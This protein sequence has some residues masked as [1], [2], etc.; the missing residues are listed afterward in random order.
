METNALRRRRVLSRSAA[1]LV[2]LAVLASGSTALAAAWCV[3]SRLAYVGYVAVALR[4]RS[5]AGA[6]APQT[7]VEPA[8]QRFSARASWLMFNDAV[9]IG[10]LCLVTRGTLDLP[11]PVW[12][13]VAAGLVLVAVGIGVKMWATASLPPGAF[14]WRSFFVTDDVVRVSATGPYRWLA[15]PMYTLGYAHAYGFALVA[16]SFWGLMGAAFAQ[17]MILLLAAVVERPQLQRLRE[18]AAAGQSMTTPP[19]AGALTK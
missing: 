14:H 5:A 18:R 7:D 15:S 8:W 4:R 6:M 2:G 11:L 13:T 10:A 9:A 17:A 3:A 19:A 12:V 1:V 16:R